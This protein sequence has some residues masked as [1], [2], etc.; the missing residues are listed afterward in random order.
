MN[1]DDPGK[2]LGEGEPK[3]RARV[4]AV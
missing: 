1:G 4:G 3:M 2:M